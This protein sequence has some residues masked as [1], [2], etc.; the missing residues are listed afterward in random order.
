MINRIA[1][2][3]MEEVKHRTQ[4]Y[5]AIELKKI[6]DSDAIVVDD[7]VATGYSLFTALKYIRNMKPKSLTAAVPVSTKEAHERLKLY[8]DNVIC[9]LVDESYFFA[10]ANYYKEWYDLTEEEIKRILT[11]YQEKYG[12]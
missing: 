6:R 11:D 4:I 10:V 3:I 1:A 9:P 8:A 7:G 5:G 12:D 2:R